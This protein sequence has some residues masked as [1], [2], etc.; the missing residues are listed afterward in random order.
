MG[1]A[2]IAAADDADADLGH[3]WQ[4]SDPLFEIQFATGC[5]IGIF[6]IGVSQ[7]GNF[8]H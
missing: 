4:R 7:C 5:K 3:A 6:G 8:G 1:L 2:H